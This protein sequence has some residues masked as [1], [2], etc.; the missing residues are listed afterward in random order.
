M[1]AQITG[2]AW[3]RKEDYE[4]VISI[5]KD[6]HIFARRYEDWLA[7][8]E[9][10]QRRIEAQGMR[11][12]RAEIDPNT[13]PAWCAAN[14][15]DVDAKGRTAFPNRAAFEAIQKQTNN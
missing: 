5:S 10:A 12:V 6:G 9:Q 15:V 13:F 7:A 3:Y 11:V 8:A 2:L 1:K 4:R 14:G